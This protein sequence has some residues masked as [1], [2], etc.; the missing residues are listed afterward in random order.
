MFNHNGK[1][2]KYKVNS[3]KFLVLQVPLYL[4]NFSQVVRPLGTNGL[5]KKKKA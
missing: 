3:F 1:I 2:R 4:S 5:K